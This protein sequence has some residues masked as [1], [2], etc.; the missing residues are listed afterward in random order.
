[1]WARSPNKTRV[2][3]G[4]TSARKYCW[5]WIGDKPESRTGLCSLRAVVSEVH[6]E[7]VPA[8]DRVCTSC[9]TK[10]GAPARVAQ[11]TKTG[12]P[13]GRPVGGINV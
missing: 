4:E 11:T 10:F 3:G 13:E 7:R 1:M 5:H 9:E 6:A 2:F 12:R 8:E